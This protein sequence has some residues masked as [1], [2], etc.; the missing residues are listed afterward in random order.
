MQIY[1]QSLFARAAFWICAEI[2][3]SLLGLDNLA[4]YS[5]F[6]FQDRHHHLA[7]EHSVVLVAAI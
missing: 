1:W 2:T 3:L 6:I 5:E 7:S 4:D